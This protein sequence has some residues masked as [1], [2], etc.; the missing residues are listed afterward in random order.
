MCKFRPLVR[1]QASAS[2]LPRRRAGRGA[3][4]RRLPRVVPRRTALL[5][6]VALAASI[7]AGASPAAALADHGGAS[8]VSGHKKEDSVAAHDPATERRL[9]RHTMAATASDAEAAAAAISDDEGEV[10]DWGPVVNWP[11]VGVHVALLENGKVLAYDSVGDNAT[12]TYEVHDHTRATVWNPATGTHTLAYVT[13]GYNVF[14]SGLAHLMDGTLFL[15]GGNLNAQFDGLVQTHLFASD[16]NEWSLGQNMA[17]GRWYPSVTPL[18]NGEMLITEGGPDVPEVRRTDGSL[19]ALSTAA[20]NLPLYPWIDVAPDGRAFYSGPNETMRSLDTA[21]KGS[22]QSFGQRDS[23]I[24]DYGSHAL[25]DVGKILVAGGASSSSDTRV[26]DLNGTTPQ[27]SA[28]EPMASGRRQ[29]NLTVLA[30]GTVLATGGNSSGAASVDLDNGVYPAELWDPATGQW[31]TLA[32]MQ[33]TRQY[34]STALLLPDARVLSSGGGICAACDEEGYLAKNAE[35]FSPPYLFRK[36]GSGEL[37]SRPTISSAPDEVTYNAPFSISTPSASSIG[38]VALVRL[39]AVTHSVNMEQRYVPLSFTAGSGALN[40]TSP[41]NPN[42]APPGVYMLFVI[43]AN[44]VPSVARMVRVRHPTNTTITGG[45]NGATNDPT[46][47]FTFSSSEPGSSFECKLDD[48]AYSACGSPITMAHLE[49]GSHT[50]TVRATDPSGLADPSPASR[51]FTVRTAAVS[52]SGST[53]VVTAAIGA[54]DNLAITRPSPSIL[55]VT[56][57]AAGA[58]TGSGVSVGAG[59]T[60]SGD[61]TANC[62]A[63]GITLIQV[64]AGDQIDSVVNSTT[65]RS[66]LGGGD[67]NDVLTGGSSNDTLT[68]AA[69]ADVMRGMD[70]ND[71][72]RARDL[73]ADTEISCDGGSSPGT[74]D[75]AQLDVRSHDPDFVVRDCETKTRY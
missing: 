6:S 49:D 59:C 57:L 48:G 52:V 55:R 34:H 58:Y 25:Y 28:T 39:G 19:R 26:I 75:K 8:T 70:G 53:L 14:C 54:K 63:S 45:P 9:Q 10:G 30:D 12:E 72:L 36:D 2:S 33:V 62:S 41:P 74:A 1:R 64:A 65:I 68:G 20:L 73:T 60:R 24:R 40:A 17:A 16:T 11:V 31:E 37:A 4:P 67:A 44:G 5:L 38:K 21:G 47:T 66:S 69:G 43:R 56:D 13:T 46:P 15:A 42:V 3:E 29:H 7:S 35:V 51:S 23:L 71:E 50:L 18:R 61:H 22:W 27:V 32:A